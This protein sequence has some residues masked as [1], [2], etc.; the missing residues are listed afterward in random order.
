[1]KK[2]VIL[3]GIL[4][5]SS[6]FAFSKTYE[7]TLANA[8]KV[9]SVQLK[10]GQYR[11]KVNGD[12][13]VFTDVDSSKQYTVPVKVENGAKKFD[14]TRVDANKDGSVDTVKDIQLGGSTTQID[15]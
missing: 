15:F 14:E 2:T 6:L 4:A 8:S 12:K 9:G 11:V 1:M 3:T 5:V 10:A 13:A 7:I